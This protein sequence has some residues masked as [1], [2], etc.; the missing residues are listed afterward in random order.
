M[1][2]LPGISIVDVPPPPGDG[3]P[4]MDVPVFVGFAARGPVDRPVAIEDAGQYA[5]VFGGA[6]ELAP[7]AGNPQPLR[8]HLPAAVAAFFAGGGRR[9][10]VVRVAG[11]EAD[12]ARF[13]VR[14]LRLATRRRV[15]LAAA[16]GAGGNAG[17]AGPWTLATADFSLRA[18]SPGAWADDDELAARLNG[19]ALHHG[20]RVRAGDVLRAR[21]PDADGR[22]DATLPTGWLRV[23]AASLVET[24]LAQAGADA[25]LWTAPDAAAPDAAAPD[26]ATPDAATPDAATPDASPP[27]P[28]PDT[29]HWLI[30]RIG[31]D[32]ALRHP[33]RP[34]LRRDGCAL[35]AGG[36]DLP[37]FEP[38]TAARF[39]AATAGR[40]S[41]ADG[42]AATGAATDPGAL[43]SLVWPLAGPAPAE[44]AG[45]AFSADAS[46]PLDPAGADWML[47]P[48]AVDADFGPWSPAQTAPADALAR[49]GLADYRASLFLDP[50][51]S[52]DLRGA[53][54]LRWADDIRFLS[55]RPR[56]LR[57]LHA[58]LGRDD[59]VARDAT[60][61]A[62]PDATHAG[63]TVTAPPPRRDGVIT[64]MPDPACGCDDARPAFG[65]CVQPPRPP[66][67][68]VIALQALAGESPPTQATPACADTA[69]E[70]LVELPADTEWFID[71]PAPAA[72]DGAAPISIEAQLAHRPDFADAR[73]L[74]PVAGT[75]DDAPVLDAR[76]RAIAFAPG[77]RI[78]APAR[79]ALRLPAGLHYLRAR[80]WRAGLASDWS[81]PL[82][83]HAIGVGRIANPGRAASD[84]AA[85]NN[86]APD[87]AVLFPVH[88]ALMDL[89]AATREHFA[90]LSLPRDWAPADLAGHAAALRARAARDV[91]AAQA[92]S[93]VAVHHPWLLR[94][95]DGALVAHPPEGAVLGVYARRS[96]ARGAW[97]AAGLDPL[98][99]AVALAT[100]LDPAAFEDAGGNAIE[101][102]PR[103]IA[104]T[105]ASTLSDD[106]DWTSIGV[107]RLFILLR[108]LARREGERF[109]F[110]PNDFTL[111]RSLERSFDALL[112]RLMQGGAFRGSRAPDCYLLRTA[113]GAEAASEIER[114]ECSLEIRVA[115]SR[116]LR[117]LTLRVV[118][119]GEQLSIE[120]H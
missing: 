98:A 110:E 88:A 89:C 68:P 32:L 35:A 55:A 92:T 80:V 109:A 46:A 106:A 50:A 38:D 111:R 96:R 8:A 48:V 24:V 100:L 114:G 63:W 29:T 13:A 119:A 34:T 72:G 83:V 117:F 76:G 95:E 41:L 7:E 67:P 31:V 115:P 112:Q 91:Q 22:A 107:R 58:A 59:A 70:Q 90:L 102:R 85:G 39:D 26:A 99:E 14:G 65:A 9:C 61:I 103:G 2:R 11:D 10:Y 81:A 40:A 21:R 19:S 62:V 43:T 104:A 64:P 30:D 77:A 79:Y 97:S 73:P 3:L 5:T 33:A 86:A 27:A 93:F 113:A 49:M 1:R 60:W 56:R 15:A 23:E 74:V 71:A 17:I 44:L 25:W 28:L 20:D 12:S 101:L 116:P 42:A 108:R 51:W 69:V 18:N 45:A 75:P 52:D 6:V 105:R 66:Q 84:A 82:A 87:A 53:Q 16:D 37:W 57:G 47:L 54:L 118:R 78:H 4:V 36:S 120:E 94:A